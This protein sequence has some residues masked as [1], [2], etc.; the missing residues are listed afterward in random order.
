MILDSSVV[1]YKTYLSHPIIPLTHLLNEF[2]EF[3]ARIL[4]TRIF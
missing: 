1:A 4:I 3:N 2:L